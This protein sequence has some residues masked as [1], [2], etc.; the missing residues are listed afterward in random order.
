MTP[1]PV[2][3][4]LV[5]LAPPL[6]AQ[7]SLLSAEQRL[8]LGAFSQPGDRFGSSV[9][10]S[11]DGKILVVGAPRS[12]TRGSLSGAAHVFVQDSLGTFA[13]DMTFPETAEDTAAFDAYGYAVAI[14]GDGRVIAVGAPL[15]DQPKGNAGKIYIWEN[16]GRWELKDQR[17][18]E[19][20]NVNDEFGTS[21]A[22]SFNGHV[23][24][25]GAPQPN[26]T[27]NPH[28]VAYI[29]VKD[30]GTW[31]KR[32]RL[33]AAGQPYD[34]FGFS[35]AIDESGSV[36]VVG[37]PGDGD[38]DTGAVYVFERVGESWP[39]LPKGKLTPS[40]PPPGN[41][42]GYSVAVAAGGGII[43]VGARG[44]GTG[45]ATA[46]SAYVF[47]RPAGEWAD[48][49]LKP[50]VPGPDSGDLGFGT[51]VAIDQNAKTILV[52]APGKANGE[53]VYFF[54]SVGMDWVKFRR[55]TCTDESGLAGMGRSVAL[56]SLNQPE[57]VGAAGAPLNAVEEGAVCIL[58]LTGLEVKTDLVK[59]EEQLQHCPITS[60]PV[61]PG[62]A[63]QYKVEV[64]NR[65]ALGPGKL[66]L[67]L[68][69][70]SNKLSEQELTCVVDA[71]ECA[72]DKEAS[73]PGLF[74]VQLLLEP[75]ASTVDRATII[76][77][78]R[79]RPEA[80]GA[81]GI[82]AG[83]N[84]PV[85][86]LDLTPDRRPEPETL[87]PDIRFHFTQSVNQSKAFRNDEIRYTIM[88]ENLGR[89]RSLNTSLVDAFNTEV[90][91]SPVGWTCSAERG[92]SCGR[93]EQ[94]TGN[95]QEAFALPP[96][97][98]LVYVATA[99]VL[100]SIPA[101]TLKNVAVL[102]DP[103]AEVKR[104]FT[105]QYTII[106]PEADLK[107]ELVSADGRLAPGN[108]FKV[109]VKVTNK[110]PD[111]VVNALLKGVTSGKEMDG[112]ERSVDITWDC[113]GIS[114]P[115]GADTT[116]VGTAGIEPQLRGLATAMVRVDAPR[117]VREQDPEDNSIK[118]E[119]VVILEPSSVLKITVPANRSAKPGNPA[120]YEVIVENL[121]PSD[122]LGASF[123]ADFSDASFERKSLRWV[124]ESSAGSLCRE[125]GRG[126]ITDHILLPKGGKLKYSI[127]GSILPE[128]RKPFLLTV[129]AEAD[130]GE[131]LSLVG[132]LTMET[133]LTPE[134]VVHFAVCPQNEDAGSTVRYFV[135]LYNQGP[136]SLLEAELT[137]S[138]LS[139]LQNVGWSCRVLDPSA[140]CTSSGEGG[141]DDKIVMP[142][143]SYLQYVVSATTDSLP[144]VIKR[145][146]TGLSNEHVVLDEAASC[147]QF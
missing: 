73:Q 69:Y 71:G 109:T 67:E 14:S 48:Q 108:A 81:I 31:S 141:I 87:Q 146:L 23:L 47:K 38:K 94:G 72:V 4:A 128:W 44:A 8:D 124:C 84:P 99:R 117:G 7:N 54:R 102:Q 11:G 45:T 66:T 25:A 115:K 10:V 129:Q 86:A 133:K 19:D 24:M 33:A 39:E 140:M 130:P 26:P 57:G 77:K 53:A 105:E 97:G 131:A 139:G 106:Q 43:A 40:Q 145:S 59:A 112:T 41:E 2:L 91:E 103:E 37:A 143:G 88:V 3:L 64:L 142:V 78:A 58:D 96:D 28:G 121:G 76:L 147:Y 13:R 35:V 83:F 114:L 56:S 49:S 132:T 101:Q 70:P 138:F 6:L 1:K 74:V 107:V 113:G 68:K 125:V 126:S 9:A 118:P 123:S 46:G 5:F 120:E 51:S 60:R 119:I 95:L 100:E 63:V 82:E 55:S 136:S 29:F 144:V 111:A 135:N 12:G 18:I 89:S 93:R 20:A 50:N 15:H 122:L 98:K 110:G 104:A 17:I 52:G 137:M 62:C 42:F 30:G 90:L 32:S 134:S 34:F 85:P 16:N 79:V 21:V 61:V 92:A 65:S 80:R 36:A 75:K 27:G 127:S 116:C 22:L